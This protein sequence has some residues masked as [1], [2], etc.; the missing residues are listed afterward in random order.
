MDARSLH[1]TV[2]ALG[3]HQ[4]RTHVFSPTGGVK[5]VETSA[6]ATQ[7]SQLVSHISHA[8][9]AQPQKGIWRSWLVLKPSVSSQD[10]CIQCIYFDLTWLPFSYLNIPE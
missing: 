8:T 2:D 9:E 7:N 6:E 4:S 10:P 3:S 1:F 5:E